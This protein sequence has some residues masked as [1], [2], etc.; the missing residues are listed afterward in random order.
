MAA[1]AATA[2]AAADRPCRSTARLLIEKS[3]DATLADQ[4]LAGH[5]RRGSA[6]K[7]SMEISTS[8]NHRGFRARWART[9]IIVCTMVTVPLVTPTAAS[10]ASVSHKY[11]HFNMCGNKCNSGGLSVADDVI[12]S[13][14]N[15][16]PQPFAVTLNEVCRGQWNRMYSALGPYYGRFEVTVPGACSNGD[17]YGIGVLVKTWDYTFRR[18]MAAARSPRAS[19]TRL[20]QDS[21]DRRRNPAAGGLRHPHRLPQRRSGG[22][23]P[24]R[25]EQRP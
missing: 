12:N 24:V 3:T 4:L 22:P 6:T 19:Q 1:T 13:V 10:A 18:G 7:R 9:M 20:H 8:M 15:S 21:R 25:G 17:D 11:F 2:P 5:P 16:S 14:N 23:D